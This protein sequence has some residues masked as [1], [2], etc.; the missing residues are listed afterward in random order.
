VLHGAHPTRA[1]RQVRRQG[2]HGGYLRAIDDAADIPIRWTTDPAE[3]AG[4]LALRERVFCGEQGVPAHEELDGLD[5]EAAHLVALDGGERVIGT[6]RLLEHGGTAKVGR[7][8]VD[9]AWRRRGIAQRMLELALQRAR[10]EGCS[11]ARLAAQLEAVEL[12]E[13]AGFAVESGRFFEA[14]I[15]HVW[16]GTGLR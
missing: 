14:G 6:L 5:D 7:V 15:E 12:Y 10:R 16:M 8:A 1:L 4:A 13:K 2:A 11:R 9:A 3:R